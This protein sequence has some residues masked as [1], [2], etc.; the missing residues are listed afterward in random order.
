MLHQD[1]STLALCTSI[2]LRNPSNPWIGP[3]LIVAF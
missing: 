1:P 3:V 2:A